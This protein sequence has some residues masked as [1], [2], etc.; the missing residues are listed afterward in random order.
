MFHLRERRSPSIARQRPSPPTPCAPWPGHDQRF[1]GQT[2]CEQCPPG[3]YQPGPGEASCV[4]CPT[5]R[6]SL[7]GSSQ[8]DFCAEGYYRPNTMSPASSCEGCGVIKGVAC[9]TDSVIATL[10]LTAGHWRH[11]NTSMEIWRCKASGSWSPCYGGG[12]AGFEGNGY[13]APG[14]RG[15]RCE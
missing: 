14:Y 3:K 1:S 8:C 5:G 11:S 7:A 10:H 9:G 6:G 12:D 13:C 4:V 15:P 2:G